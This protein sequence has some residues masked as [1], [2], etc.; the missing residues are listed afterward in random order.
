MSLLVLVALLL[1]ATPQAP[2]PY[3][4]GTAT[5]R[6]HIVRTDGPPLAR[7]EVRL[8]SSEKAGPPRIATTDQSGAYEF[9]ALPAG[10]YTLTA[11]KTGY[12]SLEFG[13]RRAFEAGQVI[14]IK[15]GETRERVDVAL[16][17][18]GAITGRIVDENGE[19]LEGVSI[20]VNEVRSVGGRRRLVILPGVPARQTNELGRFRVYG[21][22]PGDYAVRAEIAQA[23]SD[24]GRGYPVTYFPGTT[25]S[26]EA[27][28]IRI[29][30]S[31]EVSNVDFAVAPVRTARITG[32]TFTSAGEPF[33]GGVQM[34][35][36]WRSTGTVAEAV[37]GR[38]LPDGGFEFP[39]VP[40]GEYV[41][42][43]FKGIEIGWQIVVVN[44]ADV[45]DLA[46]KTLPGSTIT[47]HVTFEGG[48]A[49]K[50]DQVELVTSPADPDLTSFFGTSSSANVHEDGTFEIEH[51]TGPSRLRV[52]RA[53]SGWALQRVII[54]GIDAT[55]AALSFGAESESLKDVEIV[56]TNALT[57]MTG[58]VTDSRGTPVGDGT[59][60]VFSDDDERWYDGSRYIATSRPGRD[61]TFEISG[62]PPGR[63]FAIAVDRLP[64]SDAWRDRVFLKTLA[65]TAMR[66]TLTEGERLEVSITIVR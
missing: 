20:S 55:D 27:Q 40:S 6:G 52:A 7:A 39:N 63:Y 1:G 17:R 2:L 61:G 59:V 10:R 33:E 50:A 64:E 16:P 41:I 18:H 43:A 47:G 34:R 29:G 4:V 9:T 24:D 62:L 8:A 42:Q 28:R 14:Q 3:S 54:G 46:V 23:G 35:P 66:I 32:G 26:A 45:T 56:L 30:L 38:P 31:E 58:R 22:P 5:I 37:G 48:N 49:P 13:Q 36:T 21:L 51:V 19:P 25:H 44:G 12:V 15:A 57:R 53:P 11:I 60:I 65:A